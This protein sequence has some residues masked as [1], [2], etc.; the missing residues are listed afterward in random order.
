MIFAVG[1]LLGIQVPAFVD[2]YEARVDAHYREVS[3]NISGFQRTADVLFEGDLDALVSYYRNSSDRVFQSDADSVALI[4][5]R[6]RRLSAEQA[7]LQGSAW[8]RFFHVLMRPDSE[9]FDETMEEYGYTVPL[10]SLAIFWGVGAA[11]VLLLLLDL[12]LFSCNHC[13][14]WLLGRRRRSGQAVES[15]PE[16]SREEQKS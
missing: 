10:N 12:V 7:A 11:I 2:Q 15:L 9:F 4:V 13:S 5:S 16:R 14:R 8:G 1:L 3:V 6:Y